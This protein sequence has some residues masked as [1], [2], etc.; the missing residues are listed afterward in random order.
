MFHGMVNFYRRFLPG[1]AKALRPLMDCLWG[2]PKGPTPVE[3][4][5][6]KEAAFTEVKQMLASAT[7][8]AHPAQ[9]A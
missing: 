3:W 2:I 5:C 1:A 7:R 4:N 6:E 9:S 8:L